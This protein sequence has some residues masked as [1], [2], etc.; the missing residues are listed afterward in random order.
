MKVNQC[1][2][3]GRSFCFA[4]FVKPKRWWW[5]FKYK[6]K[7]RQFELMN[8]CGRVKGMTKCKNEFNIQF[9]DSEIKL[10]KN[11]QIYL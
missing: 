3:L 6:M 8:R 4:H 9:V 2:H 11:I 5:K 7:G 1:F 10:N